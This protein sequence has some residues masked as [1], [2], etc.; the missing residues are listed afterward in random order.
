MNRFNGV[1]ED[2]SSRSNPHEVAVTHLQW[3]LEV[4]FDRRVVRGEARYTIRC[5]DN[6]S[7][8]LSLDTAKLDIEHVADQDGNDLDWSLHRE[9]PGKEFLGS[10]L[11]IEL[12]SDSITQVVISY[13]T[14]PESTALQWLDPSQTVGKAYPYLFSQC[15][16]IHARSMLPC[17]DRPGVKFTFRAKVR[18]PTWAVCVMSAVQIHSFEDDHKLGK[19]SVWMQDIPVSSYLIAL[20]VGQLERK[21]ISPRCALWSEP[22]IVNIA[23]REFSDTEHILQTA[24]AFSGLPYVWGRYDILCLPPSFPY[25][26]MENP[27]LSFITPVSTTSL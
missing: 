7:A 5:M 14:S 6:T 2:R 9:E 18:V 19:V 1:V 12:N 16:A 22:A 24:E 13:E 10:Q 3:E 23:A 17:Q 15:Q 4:D 21:E 8:W 25:G 27:C 11:D 20:A 26:G